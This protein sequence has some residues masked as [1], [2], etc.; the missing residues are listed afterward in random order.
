MKCSLGNETRKGVEGR[1]EE[2]RGR[3]ERN[4]TEILNSA[5]KTWDRIESKDTV[6]EKSGIL[7]N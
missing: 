5:R 4:I 2:E 7:R 1:G 6:P 3:R